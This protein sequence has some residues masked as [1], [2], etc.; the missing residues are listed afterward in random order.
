MEYIEALNGPPDDGCFLCRYRDKP[1]DDASNLVLWRGQYCM[2]LLN[3]FPYTGG[4]CMVTPFRHVPD[5]TSLDPATM[6]E[7]M[8]MLRDLQATLAA[9]MKCEGFN[10]GMNIGRCAGAGLPGHLHAHL[11]PR[12][13]GDTNFM[14]VF[15]QVRVIPQHLDAIY[16]LITEKAKEL[17]LPKFS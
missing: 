14:A 1:A 17:G 12:W 7:M 16:K 4:H 15:A 10:V 5:L 13:S 2:A 8:Q 6:L 11:V 9:A 3:R